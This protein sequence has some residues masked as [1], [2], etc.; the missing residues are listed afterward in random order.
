MVRNETGVLRR[1]N[2]RMF[3]KQEKRRGD[4]MIFDDMIFHNVEELEA[5]NNGY[6]MWRLPKKIINHVNEGI[7]NNTGRYCTGVELRFKMKSD[8]VKLILRSEDTLEAQVA[9]IYYGSM[10]GG[11]QNSSKMIEKEKSEIVIEKPDNLE[12]LKGISK[13][14]K[15]AFDP[16]VV[17]VVLPYGAI[18]YHGIDGDIELP[19]ESELPDTTYL[20]YGSSITHG[21]LAL[22]APY[23]YCFRIAQKFKSD[24]VNMGFAGS[25]QMEKSIAD[26]IIS[27]K[28]W[29]FASFEMGI[30][31]VNLPQNLFEE[32][33]KEF[34]KVLGEDNRPMIITNIYGNNM[35][36]EQQKTVMRYREIVKYYYDINLNH[37]SNACFVDGLDLLNNSTFLSQDLVHPS[38]EGID[39][40]ARNMYLAFGKI[41]C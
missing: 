26:Y 6:I 32:R 27:R 18:Y 41:K 4:K 7:Q 10:Q 15:M 34:T 3:Q 35:Q 9:Y 16:S 38:L 19:K 36:G 37:K 33:V 22:A 8:K 39:E 20:A 11:W 31:M 25:A 14:K 2:E 23:T 12:V 24:Y 17:R 30:N 5:T 40:I 13:E 28:D 1:S 21:S 29:N